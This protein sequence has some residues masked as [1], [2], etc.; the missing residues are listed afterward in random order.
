[1]KEKY[2][3]HR[4]SER[5]RQRERET[6]REREAHQ[7]SSLLSRFRILPD[8]WQNLSY[9]KAEEKEQIYRQKYH[10]PY[11]YCYTRMHRHI[12]GHTHKRLQW[13]HISLL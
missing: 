5:E 7:S 8:M 4:H 13:V 6:D 10:K 3:I 11:K 12:L 1:M 9:R 2:E